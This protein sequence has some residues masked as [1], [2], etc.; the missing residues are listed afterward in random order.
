[1][2][3]LKYLLI[4]AYALVFVGSL[5]PA[6]ADSPGKEVFRE[7]IPVRE[8]ETRAEPIQ[9]ER[10]VQAD[11]SEWLFSVSPTV[12]MVFFKDDRNR[13]LYGL[14]FNARKSDIP[15]NYRI[16]IEGAHFDSENPPIERT[17]VNSGSFASGPELT[18]IRI[19]IAIEY[20]HEVNED[21]NLY[22][23]PG[24]DIIR[25]DNIVEDTGTAL[26]LSGRLGYE[27]TEDWEATVEGGYMF[28]E[29]L[30]TPEGDADFSGPFVAAGLAYNF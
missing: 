8:E 21:L 11:E 25:I 5:K 10:M 4:T 22:A 3:Y 27:L 7:R 23:G 12:N 20:F 9:E 29:D 26:H 17:F 1:M 6:F 14:H 28:A 13:P 18:F 24:L 19:P 15:I 16:G 2:N 30:S